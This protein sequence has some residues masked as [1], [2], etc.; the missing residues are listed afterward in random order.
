MVS[1]EGD[2]GALPYCVPSGDAEL[3]FGLLPPIGELE[4]T[5]LH[6]PGKCPICEVH[7]TTH[8][9]FRVPLILPARARSQG[10]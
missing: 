8:P 5:T 3:F 1:Q 2:A 10:Y 7:S 9:T 6:S 4:P